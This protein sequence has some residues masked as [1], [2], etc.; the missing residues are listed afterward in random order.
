[1]IDTQ[2]S[3]INETSGEDVVSIS[4]DVSTRIRP[5]K[6]TDSSSK[7]QKTIQGGIVI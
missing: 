3:T 4:Q 1:M 7:Q 2:I 5:S 6:S